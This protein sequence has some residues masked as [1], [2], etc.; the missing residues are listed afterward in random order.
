MTTIIAILAACC[1]FIAGFFCAC[2]LASA[3]KPLRCNRCQGEF[4]NLYDAEYHDCESAKG[5]RRP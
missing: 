4:R 3:K 1:G 2:I 5:G